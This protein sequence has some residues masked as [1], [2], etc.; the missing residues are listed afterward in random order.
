MIGFIGFVCSIGLICRKS[1]NQSN[2]SN[3]S[4]DIT[5]LTESLYVND[6]ASLR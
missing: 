2:Q 3:Q 1:F 4:N 6:L 5:N